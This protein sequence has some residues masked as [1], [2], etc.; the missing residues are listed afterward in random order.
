LVSLQSVVIVDPF[1][2]DKGDDV[3][4]NFLKW[5][6]DEAKDRFP[7]AIEFENLDTTT[8]KKISATR[9]E[10]NHIFTPLQIDGYSCGAL[11]AMMAYFYIM[12]GRLPTRQ[13]FT[14]MPSHVKEIRLFMAFE[15]ARLHS[16]PEMYTDGENVLYNELPGLRRDRAAARRR[17]NRD[18]EA[19]MVSASRRNADQSYLFQGLVELDKEYDIEVRAVIDLISPSNSPLQDL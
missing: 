13:D 19:N 14:S 1:L 9:H 7:D 10:F 4:T 5:Y 15:I 12:Y 3:A 6:Q 16:I 2:H 17:R 11:S 8:W 18:L